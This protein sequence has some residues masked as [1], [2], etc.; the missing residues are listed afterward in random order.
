MTLY[1]SL[2]A[3]GTPGLAES[4]LSDTNQEESRSSAGPSSSGRH[5]G[6]TSRGAHAKHPC[7]AAEQRPRFQEISLSI[8]GEACVPWRHLPQA[9][10][11]T[12]PPHAHTLTRIQITLQ[13]RIV[14]KLFSTFLSPPSPGGLEANSSSFI[15]TDLHSD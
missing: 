3:A 5:T 1:N 13:N 8:P 11:S 10:G 7:H 12:A 2:F 9:S 15:N 4:V 14:T 6:L